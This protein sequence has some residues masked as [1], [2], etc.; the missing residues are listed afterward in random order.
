MKSY[1][2]NDIKFYLHI[3]IPPTV[4]EAVKMYGTGD[5][6]KIKCELTYNE[7][8]MVVHL[9]AV[10]IETIRNVKIVIN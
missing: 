5:T 8:G 3:H 2:N 1:K 10:T 7:N 9:T 4:I 6:V